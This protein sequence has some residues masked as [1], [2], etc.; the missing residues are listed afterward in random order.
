[1]SIYSMHE[2]SMHERRGIM[3]ED[4]EIFALFREISNRLSI[5]MNKFYEPYGLTPV[6]FIILME[7]MME[8]HQ[9]ISSL[10]NKVHM[11]NSNL[12]AILKRMEK[13]DLIRRCRDTLDQRVVHI[14]LTKKAKDICDAMKKES[15]IEQE[16]ILHISKEDR[17]C[18]QK[19]LQVLN[20]ILK[21][22]EDYE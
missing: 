4:K 19:G 14:Q 10:G 21:E 1:M 11:S 9:T 16:A 20:N 13:H 12:S 8:E 15:C 18:I 3:Q 5:K 6:Q 7:I 22:C 2:I 17:A